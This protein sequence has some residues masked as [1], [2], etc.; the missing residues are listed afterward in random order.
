MARLVP[1]ARI[2]G[3][4]CHIQPAICLQLHTK[5]PS[6]VQRAATPMSGHVLTSAPPPPPPLSLRRGKLPFLASS[7]PTPSV[8]PEL[9]EKA[10]VVKNQANQLFQGSLLF[11]R[12]SGDLALQLQLHPLKCPLCHVTDLLS[13]FL[14]LLLLLP[15]RPNFKSPFGCTPS[16]SCST[17]L[18]PPITPTGLLPTSRR[19]AMGTPFSMLTRPLSST[20][21]MSR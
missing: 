3:G 19:R 4:C 2:R 16:Q 10:E 14:L 18:S 15:Q 8:I 12:C 1:F 7:N 20:R 17:P 13:I 5:S 9:K 11:A 6:K 21:A